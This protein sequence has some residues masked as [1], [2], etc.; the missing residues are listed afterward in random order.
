MSGRREEVNRWRRRGGTGRTAGMR[1]LGM[2]G[3]VESCGLETSEG[4]CRKQEREKRS[5]RKV[6]ASTR[7]E[8]HD[9]DRARD[10]KRASRRWEEYIERS[11]KFGPKKRRVKGSLQDAAGSEKRRKIKSAR[12]TGSF[13]ESR[14]THSATSL[15]NASWMKGMRDPSLGLL[16]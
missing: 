10:R 9:I 5:Q 16:P 1:H 14:S 15:L 6:D 8:T 3:F 7:D 4:D 13:R 2:T 11:A 12:R